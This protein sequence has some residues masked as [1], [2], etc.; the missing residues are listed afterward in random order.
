MECGGL[1]DAGYMPFR[2]RIYERAVEERIPLTGSM[3]VT[4]RCNLRCVHCYISNTGETKPDLSLSAIKS[5]V[6]QLAEEGCLWLLITGGEPLVRPDFR[7]IYTY[8]KRR[9]II[10]ILFTNGTL[11]TEEIADLLESMPPYSVEI[12]IYGST[13][14]TFEAVTGIPGSFNACMNGIERLVK[15]GIKL[16]LKTMAMSLN[17]HEVQSMKSLA[18]ELGVPFRFDTLLN[19]T[20]DGDGCPAGYRLSPGRTVSLDEQDTD[21]KSE[22]NDLV[23]KF[24]GKA[25]IHDRIFQ[26]GAGVCTFHI[27]S[28]GLLSVCMM[29]REK[30]FDLGKGTFRDGWRLYLPNVLAREWSREVPCRTCT[31]K[32]MCGQ[33]PGWGYLEHGDPEEPVDYLCKVAHMRAE[34]LGISCESA[35]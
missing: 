32:S 27:D 31:L 6:D 23:K 22:W 17:V 12:S 10:P 2:G 21:R 24:P 1:P 15:R 9:G 14:R 34:M 13:E 28:T 26:C 3:E 25:R 8:V 30:S 35:T 20:L 7:E 11:I 4:S 19:R 16:H 18:G 29:Y 33:C 5:I